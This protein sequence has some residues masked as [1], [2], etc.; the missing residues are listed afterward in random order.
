[1]LLGVADD[2]RQAMI[3]AGERIAAERGLAAMSLREVQAAA[4]QRNK[5][6]AQYHFGSRHGLIEAIVATRMGPINEQRVAMLERLDDAATV[7][8]VRQLVEFL[9]EPLAEATLRPGSSWAR[10]LV[11]GFADPELSEVVRRTFEGR[12]YFDTL[13]RLAA[14]S[15][16]LPEEV[17]QRRVDHAVGLAVMSLAAAEAT[18][19]RRGRP[20]LPSEALVADLIDTCSAVIDA[21]ASPTTRAAL[22]RRTRPA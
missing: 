6:A 18:R 16:H 3:E 8:T 21:P 1:M 14:A 2:A 10:F 17:R 4:G 20:A 11:Q 22:E 5:S 9:V 13:A 15:D 19:A 12:A 7:P